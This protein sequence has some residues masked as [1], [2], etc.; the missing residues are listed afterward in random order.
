MLSIST[1]S[2]KKKK[3]VTKKAI[4]SLILAKTDDVTAEVVKDKFY[5]FSS[6]VNSQ[7]DTVATKII[8]SKNLPTDCKIISFNVKS[9]KL[10]AITWVEKSTTQTDTK[11]EEVTQNFAQ[12]FDITTKLKTFENIQ[13]STKIKE[14]VFLD[15]LKNASETQERMRNEGYNFSL[16]P[17]GDVSLKN[18]TQERKMTFDFSKNMYTNKK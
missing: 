8:D 17:N 9:K 4:S 13:K 11:T 18:K 14:Q 2:Q 6:V 16:L 7:K 1:Y 15:R 10:Y 12:I 3:K 5:I